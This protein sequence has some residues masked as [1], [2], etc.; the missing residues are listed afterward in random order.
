M[1]NKTMPNK[2][3]VGDAV[4]GN[5][6]HLY[7]LRHGMSGKISHEGNGGYYVLWANEFEPLFTYARELYSTSKFKAGDAVVGNDSHFLYKRRGMEGKIVE[8]Y[9]KSYSIIWKGEAMRNIVGESEIDFVTVPV[10]KKKKIKV[11]SSV[12]TT[13]VETRSLDL[14]PDQVETIVRNWAKD[15]HGFG[16]NTRIK[17]TSQFNPVAPHPMTISETISSVENNL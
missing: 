3:K 15:H 16:I 5:D 10:L 17:S 14:T 9:G 1:E 2:F 8:K 12:V 7:S 4:V 13:Q 11:T 6:S